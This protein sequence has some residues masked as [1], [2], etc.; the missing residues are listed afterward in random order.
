MGYFCGMTEQNV[1]IWRPHPGFQTRFVQSNVDFLVGGSAMGVGKQ[2][3]ISSLV[4]TPDGWKRM[5]DIHV[6][7]LVTTPFDGNAAVTG[8]YPQGVKPVYKLTTADGRTC[9]CG[10]EHLWA[11]R[12]KSGLLSHKRS[13]RYESGLQV[14]TTREII[15]KMKNGVALY[16]PLPESLEFAEKRFVI[17]P[18]IMGAVIGDGC[19]TGQGLK[20]TSFI[21]SNPEQDIIDKVAA[22]SNA[23]RVYVQPSSYSK[24]FFT[25][26]A[27]EYKKYIVNVGLNTYS[28]NKFIPEEYFWGSREQRIDLLKGLF[29][30][31]GHIGKRNRFSYSTT[32]RRLA[33]DIVRLC[34]SLGFIATINV[35][36][37]IEKYTTK[38][39]C[40]RVCIQT[41]EIVFSSK[42]HRARYDANLKEYNRKFGRTRDHIRIESIE[43]VRDDECQCIVVDSPKHLYVTDDYIVTHNSMGALL[44]AAQHTEDSNFRMVFLRRNIGDIRAGGGGTDEASRLY[45]DI[46]TLK[47]SE[48]PRL[49]FPSGAFIDFTHMSDQREDK[50]LERVKGWQY[51]CI[52]V[53][54]ATGF[55]WS[56]IRLLMSRNRSQAKWSGKMRLTCNPKRNHWLRKWVDWY[57]DEQGYPIPERDGVVRYFY[58]NGREIDDV[59]FGATPE[60]V[61][62]Q[63]KS[64]IDAILKGQGD[65]YTYRD[66]VKSTTFLSGKLAE[67]VSLMKDNAGYLG[68]VAAM[69]EKQRQ[70]NLMGCWNVDLDE[71]A[72]APISPATARA[73]ATNEPQTSSVYW[74]TA[75]LADIGTDNT[76]ILIW[77]GYHIIDYKILPSATTDRN[78]E[79]IKRMARKHN[80][81][82]N[83]IIFDSRRSPYMHERIPDA[84]AFDS[85]YSPRG[86]YKRDFMLLKDEVY[87]RLVEALN[88]GRISM[89]E[90]VANAIYLHQKLTTQITILEEF[91]EECAV[92]QFNTAASGKQRLLTKKEMNAQLGKSRSMDVLDPCAM[93]FFPDLWAE[94]GQELAHERD[95]MN[96]SAEYSAS[97]CDIYDEST[98]A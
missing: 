29:D 79:W 63:C 5:G 25:S 83:H 45:G 22:L 41:D 19:L 10:I 76:F 47:I 96:E 43:Y 37:R 92:V 11:V 50:V 52:Y 77:D 85:C 33:D 86:L 27:D 3:S 35:D 59:V 16:I 26:K 38:D 72:D 60:E 17:P 21:I 4:L 20:S 56:T 68:S 34:R 49:T 51:S 24:V 82:D 89:S 31:D 93:R 74:L 78:V 13:G 84:I 58:V 55:E 98:W 75:D 18:Y 9:E 15:G 73:I 28:Y 7:D 95:A 62:R 8:V 6:G 66:L 39:F 53:D 12:T 40:Y 70:A 14:M 61:Y 48:N 80:I 81:P 94:Y 87:M 91:A 69:G 30:T 23:H 71:D 64:S 67:N 88:G 42:K 46:A 54:E 97:A 90:E 57:V 36:K 65:G 2:Q 32:S 44:M 1:T